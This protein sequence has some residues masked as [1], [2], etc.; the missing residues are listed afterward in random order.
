MQHQHHAQHHHHHL[1]HQQQQAHHQQQN[2]AAQHQSQ[3]HAQA[4][5]QQAQQAQKNLLNVKSEP[6]DNGFEKVQES[7]AKTENL[8]DAKDGIKMEGPN[9]GLPDDYNG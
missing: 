2:V 7:I 1:H 6:V 4:A 3:Q 5:Q 9:S 8:S